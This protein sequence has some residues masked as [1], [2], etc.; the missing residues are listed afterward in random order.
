MSLSCLI[1]AWWQVTSVRN[2]PS[3]SP[4]FIGTVRVCVCVCVRVCIFV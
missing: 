1:I 4:K 3:F 2:M